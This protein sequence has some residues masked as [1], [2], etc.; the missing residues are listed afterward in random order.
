MPFEYTSMKAFSRAFLAESARFES[1]LCPKMLLYKVIS[2]KS[3]VNVSVKP[4][5]LYY[6]V[7]SKKTNKYKKVSSNKL[8]D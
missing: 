5:W 3:T 2:M 8:K 4:Q 1:C 6:E 7:V